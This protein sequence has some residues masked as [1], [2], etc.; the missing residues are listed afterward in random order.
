MCCVLI[1]SGMLPTNF[2]KRFVG[3]NATLLRGRQPYCLCLAMK[4][5]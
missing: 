3:E 5:I 1:G 2:F 4:E